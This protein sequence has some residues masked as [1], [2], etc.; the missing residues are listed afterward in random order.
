MQM[1]ILSLEH[2][3]KMNELLQSWTDVASMVYGRHRTIQGENMAQHEAMNTVYD[4]VLKLHNQ[5][6]LMITG[7]NGVSSRIVQ[8][9]NEISSWKIKIEKSQSDEIDETEWLQLLDK[10]EDWSKTCDLLKTFLGSV[11]GLET[12]EK[13]IKIDETV[14]QVSNW[15]YHTVTGIESENGRLA[16]ML[17]SIQNDMLKWMSSALLLL[18]PDKSNNI[19][20]R[21][22]AIPSQVSAVDL[23][24]QQ[25]S[26]SQWCI[27]LSEYIAK[28]SDSIVRDQFSQSSDEYT[29]LDQLKSFQKESLEWEKSSTFLCEALQA[30]VQSLDLD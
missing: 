11:V 5:L 17:T 16:A 10:F 13:D 7:E 28:C 2:L 14:K 12:G 23:C 22:I 18:V 9:L 26:L 4:T 8:V 19:V 1:A 25:E 20:L 15:L 3:Y 24:T 29:L 27:D 21:K 30:T 6:Q